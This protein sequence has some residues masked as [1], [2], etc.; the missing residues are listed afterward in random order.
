MK[1]K[2]QLITNSLFSIL[3]FFFSR[4]VGFILTP[5]VLYKLGID[6]YA[7]WSIMSSILGYLS[8]ADM[9]VGTS[10]AKFISG[11]YAKKE[12]ENINKVLN[13]GFL[14][15]LGVGSLIYA[16][17]FLWGDR[18][19]DLFHI[20]E[21]IRSEIP[22]LFHLTVLFNIIASTMDVF[23]AVL[24]G[25]QRADVIKRNRMIIFVVDAFCKVLL[26]QAGF[27]LGALVG[28]TGVVIALMIVLNLVSAFII[29]P[30]LRFSPFLFDV[31]MFRRMFGYG[32]QLQIGRIAKMS[33]MHLGKLI[34][35][36]FLP[37]S[38]VAIYDFG[39]RIVLTLQSLPLSLSP[40][41]LPAASHLFSLKNAEALRQLYARGSKYMTIVVMFLSGFFFCMM[42]LVILS[43]LGSQID[44]YSASAVA[45]ILLIGSSYFLISDVASV[46]VLGMGHP[47][48][49]L[50]ASILRLSANIVLGII[51]IPRFGFI[52]AALATATAEIFGT[53]YFAI[54]SHKEFHRSYP[55]VITSIYLLP[56]V[57]AGLAATCTFAFQKAFCLWLWEPQG[58]WQNLSLLTAA[59]LVFSCVY[60][61]ILLKSHY[62]D[63]YDKTQLRDFYEKHTRKILD[64]TTSRRKLNND[65]K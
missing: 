12:Y 9:G 20:D 54:A 43:W 55:D 60:G 7:V 36:T 27:K 29:V 65:E 51:L 63:S 45:R 31:A 41:I 11:F 19:F 46:V 50:R 30:E 5:Y 3:E 15:Y 22:L 25:G 59:L 32:I 62:I 35:A 4:V 38:A 61:M 17:V 16:F 64:F 56:F 39:N 8:K 21:P 13:T 47:E 48:Y 6:R 10:Y 1:L 52:G 24:W 37:L 57:G 14:Y 49:G 2:Q 26:L 18:V 28:T 58:R 44:V 40:S 42:P 34:L 53:G 23:G 33:Q